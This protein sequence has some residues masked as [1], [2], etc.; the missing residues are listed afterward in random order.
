M[1]LVYVAAVVVGFLL[2]PWAVTE[3]WP[4]LILLPVLYFL[5]WHAHRTTRTRRKE[6]HE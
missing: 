2:A 6:H 3:G 1:L 5:A 4:L